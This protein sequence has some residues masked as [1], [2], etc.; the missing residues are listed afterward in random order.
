MQFSI[1]KKFYSC[2]FFPIFVHQNPWIRNWIRIRIWNCNEKKCWIRIRIK[3]V[4][5]HN[6]DV[7]DEPAAPRGGGARGGRLQQIW[8]PSLQHKATNPHMKATFFS[9]L[10]WSFLLKK[11]SETNIKFNQT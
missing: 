7:Q 4:R 2:K 10:P 11:K 6:P 5:I 3:S 8:L 9:R 1:R